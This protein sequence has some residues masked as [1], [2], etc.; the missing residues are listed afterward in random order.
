MR[1]IVKHITVNCAYRG[2]TSPIDTGECVLYGRDIVHTGCKAVY[3]QQ[4][5]EME[6]FL[7]DGEPV[8]VEY[9]KNPFEPKLKH[10]TGRVKFYGRVG[11]L[12]Q[13]Y[14]FI[15]TDRSGTSLYFENCHEDVKA[16]DRVTYTPVRSK[17]SSGWT[18]AADVHRV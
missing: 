12:G 4:H 5:R 9:R 13:K 3:E 18:R 15:I 14:G 10:R 8:I 17:K 1:R 16:G 6:G 2:C 11:L 7:P